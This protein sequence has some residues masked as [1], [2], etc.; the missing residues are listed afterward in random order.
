M[1]VLTGA[2]ISADS[3]V[4]TFRGAGG[5]W[6]GHAI[7]DVATPQAWE[8]DPVLVWRFYQLRRAQLREVEPNPAHLALADL[9][10]ALKA[11]GGGL[12]LVSQNVD[13]LHQRAGSSVISMHGQLRHLRCEECGA[14]V[15]D[16]ER[17]DPDVFLPCADCGFERLRPDVVWFGE[18]PY[19]LDQIEEALRRADHFVT[20]GTSGVV[21]PAAGY[22]EW[23]RAAGLTTWVQA[24]EEPENVHPRD[25][26]L[27]GRAAQVLP[28][29]VAAWKGEWSLD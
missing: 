11:A 26:F 28:A 25:R 12:T 20:V 8:R 19:A 6:E 14:R 9:E 4:A 22:L 21:Y 15:W 18:V 17:I 3:G 16:E 29:Q 1:V 23:A 27:P 7:E 2:G 10:R 24:L 13:D 5:L